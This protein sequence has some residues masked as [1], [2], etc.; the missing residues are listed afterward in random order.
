MD[1]SVNLAIAIRSFVSKN[2]VLYSQA[3]AG[4]VIHSVE[5]KG[6]TRSE[7][8]IGGFEKSIGIGRKNLISVNNIDCRIALKQYTSN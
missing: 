1:G 3:G 7:Q 6:I 2:N 5:E 8:Q 4:I